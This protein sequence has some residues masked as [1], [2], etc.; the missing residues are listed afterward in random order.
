ML[1]QQNPENKNVKRLISA[2]NQVV[3]N[4]MAL[5]NKESAAHGKSKQQLQESYVLP[6]HARLAL[7]AAHTLSVYILERLETS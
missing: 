1:L 3:D 5:R 7:H 2:L 4:I 6:R